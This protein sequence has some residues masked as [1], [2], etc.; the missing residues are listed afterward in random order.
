MKEKV[1]YKRPIMFSILLGLLLIL[2]ITVA[3]AIAV[4]L[5]L[6]DIG[7]LVAQGLAFLFVAIIITLYMKNG[8]R[9]LSEF[10]F[11]K[12]NISK[13]KEVL[14]YIPLLVIALVHPLIGG[15][16]TDLK[17]IEVFIILIFAFLVGYTEESI[18]RGIIKKKLEFKGKIYFIVFSS[19]FFGILHVANAFSGKN[20]TSVILQVVNAFLVGL[21]LSTL[22][23]I[24][25]NII[26]L[27]A[28]HFLYDALALM[29]NSSISEKETLVL[30]VLTTLY[31]LYG[32]YL[33][34]KLKQSLRL[35]K[36][37]FKDQRV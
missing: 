7:V 18:F 23:T 19:T 14:Y 16:D 21:I 25:H 17:I 24:V 20:L 35:S 5:E 15:F 30:I 4:A 37:Q 13:S 34:F 1:S 3:S 6:T 2:C 27:I 12:L 8:K 22:I 31:T 29:T 28:F 32:I 9:S 26:P 33:I 36:I 11:E 10:G